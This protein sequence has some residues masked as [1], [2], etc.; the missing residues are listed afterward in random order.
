VDLPRIRGNRQLIA[1]VGAVKSKPAVLDGDV[2]PSEAL[3]DLARRATHAIFSEPGLAC[4]TGNDAPGAALQ[5]IAADVTGVV[6]VTLGPEGFIW[7]E[8]GREIRAKAPTN[9]PGYVGRRRRLAWGVYA[10]TR[11]RRNDRA[12][13]RLCERGGS[14]QVHPVWWSARGADPSRSGCPT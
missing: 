6:G 2:G 1:G 7:R 10:G 11:R 12:R 4:A 8:T 5:R 3:A 13:G 9:T 14:N